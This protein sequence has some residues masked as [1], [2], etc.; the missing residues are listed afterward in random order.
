MNRAISVTVQPNGNATGQAACTKS[1]Q[2]WEGVSAF[3]YS[4]PVEERPAPRAGGCSGQPGL[5]IRA[6]LAQS[7]EV[8]AALQMVPWLHPSPFIAHPSLMRKAAGTDF[9][10]I[11]QGLQ[12]TAKCLQKSKLKQEEIL[13]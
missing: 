3:H 13:L 7:R 2:G 11:Q 10:E 1:R 12:R 8:T 6:T 4:A 9:T 5:A